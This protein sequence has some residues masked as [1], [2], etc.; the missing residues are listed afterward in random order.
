M[1]QFALQYEE[2]FRS[3]GTPNMHACQHLADMM[4][5]YGPAHGW[6]CFP[7]ERM[8]GIIKE[9]EVN[10]HAIEE[11]FM[12]VWTEQDHLRILPHLTGEW[13]KLGVD[14]RAVRAAALLQESRPSAGERN[15]HRREKLR[16]QWLDVGAQFASVSLERMRRQ[17]RR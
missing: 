6:T 1:Q 4:E 17:R 14:L 15:E 12:R 7:F 2:T 3:G 8:N 16:D 13:A 10:S 5:D 11:T 9:T